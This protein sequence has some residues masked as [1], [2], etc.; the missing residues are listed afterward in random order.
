M[1]LFSP[2]RERNFW[3]LAF[4]VQ[5]AIYL[6][7]GLAN[8]LASLLR[9]YGLATPSFI[10]TL[11]LVGVA[12][13]LISFGGKV[14]RTRIGMAVG[15][16]A[17]YWMASI[18]ILALEERTHLFE[19]SLVAALIYQALLERKKNGRKVPVPAVVAV[20]VTSL[21]GLIDEGIQFFLPDRF[22][23]IQDVGFNALAALMAVGLSAGMS[24][25][26]RWWENRK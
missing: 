21:L 14:N 23:D 13:V 12:I 6:T 15:V 5:G 16:T 19:Y 25:L 8:R 9:E 10:I 20:V 1:P 22:Y 4:F 2:N 24:R 3:V 11:L 7:L 26:E 17:V 18:R